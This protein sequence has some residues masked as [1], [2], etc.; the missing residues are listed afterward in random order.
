MPG[1]QSGVIDNIGGGTVKFSPNGTPLSPPITGF[2]GMGVDGI[3][4]GTAVT[5]DK[6]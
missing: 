2:P 5:V 1:S 4:W 3:G 6:V